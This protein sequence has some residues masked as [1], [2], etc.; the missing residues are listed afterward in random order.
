MAVS[1]FD[2]FIFSLLLGVPSFI[3]S[4]LTIWALVT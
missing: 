1:F 4:S 3:Y 2:L